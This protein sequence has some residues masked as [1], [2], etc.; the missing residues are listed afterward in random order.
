MRSN[1]GK[2]CELKLL[3]NLANIP[4]ELTLHSARHTLR[5]LLSEA[6]IVDNGIIKRMMS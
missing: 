3:A 6:D 5:Q 1:K 4:I 2:N